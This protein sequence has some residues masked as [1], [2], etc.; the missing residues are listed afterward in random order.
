MEWAGG[1]PRWESGDCAALPSA[2]PFS[3]TDFFLPQK[4]DSKT[5]LPA[6]SQN[7]STDGG[8]EASHVAGV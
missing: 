6:T 2:G 7:G 8:A 1:P 5:K 4:S 3:L